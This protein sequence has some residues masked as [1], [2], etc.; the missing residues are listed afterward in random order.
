MDTGALRLFEID[1]DSRQP[2]EMELMK[3]FSTSK[4]NVSRADHC[5]EFPN[6]LA[7]ACKA[8]FIQLIDTARGTF[9][10]VLTYV[11]DH[12]MVDMDIRCLAIDPASRIVAYEQ[13]CLIY[14][15][16]HS[17]DMLYA[18]T[19][20]GDVRVL[21]SF[22]SRPSALCADGDH[23]LCGDGTGDLALL[24]SCE[25]DQPVVWRRQVGKQGIVQVAMHRTAV[26]AAC[27]DFS[28][29]VVSLATGS[30]TSSIMSASST[31]CGIAALHPHDDTVAVATTQGSILFWQPDNAFRG[32]DEEDSHPFAALPQAAPGRFVGF[33]PKPNVVHRT[34]DVNPSSNWSAVGMM[35]SV[36]I[37]SLS[38]Q[39]GFMIVGGQDGR[40]VL[41][42]ATVS[43]A[44]VK[45]LPLLT[46]H[47]VSHPVLLAT[48]T[49]D[50]HVC[51][52]TTN[53]DVWRWPIS[54][55][56]GQAESH[57]E[58]TSGAP[59]YNDSEAEVI[60]VEL[61]PPCPSNHLASNVNPPTTA[62]DDED[63][64]VVEDILEQ[65]LGD[66][67]DESEEPE[68]DDDKQESQAEPSNLS[69]PIPTPREKADD[70]PMAS[71]H[72]ASNERSESVSM[73]PS[74]SDAVVPAG[75]ANLTTPTDERRPV[76]PNAGFQRRKVHVDPV[77]IPGL[78]SGRRREPKA[79][80]EELMRE[81]RQPSQHALATPNAQ[82]T[83]QMSD[84]VRTIDAEAFDADRFAEMHK[85]AASSL[86]FTH[87]IPAAKYGLHDVLFVT[88]PQTSHPM[89]IEGGD[90]PS[91]PALIEPT[92]NQVGHHRRPLMV[93]HPNATRKRSPSPKR[94][95][96]LAPATMDSLR[97]RPDKTYLR[98]KNLAAP[99]I[100][101]HLC[102]NL[103]LPP[104]PKTIFFPELR[105]VVQPSQP[106]QLPLPVP[107]TP[108][109]F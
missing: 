94:L 8:G 100:D 70:Q 105:R 88:S 97:H 104:K 22:A 75:L 82:G 56:L 63:G 77:S 80:E 74:I 26:F 10:L 24:R 6:L 32:G 108:Q 67:M 91:P 53:G 106:L 13:L 7:L 92:E 55:I 107:P 86:P 20:T 44:T 43:V 12:P 79:V 62:E 52:V 98:Q 41:Y 38:V 59:L 39:Q 58:R 9:R 21:L 65:G 31:V 66:E 57:D 101:N 33:P 37:K 29:K 34:L 48:V 81:E 50:N 85:A 23:I 14:S 87:P 11:G 61:E 90:S 60:A 47:E 64:N 19:V 99:E 73:P 72:F 4:T 30:V 45:E 78:R 71:T 2:A 28:V 36:K 25:A 83:V 27:A 96:D 46:C 17:S 51:L 16:S 1:K 76:S 103:L 102:H 89:M 40:F 35:A 69:P 49:K 54:D 42:D 5:R 95:D 3:R 15:L 109:A 68:D 18:N 84:A 93:Q